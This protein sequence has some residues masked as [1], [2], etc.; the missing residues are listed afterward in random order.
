MPQI[1]PS[2]PLGQMWWHLTASFQPH[3]LP[4]TLIPA[5]S[6]APWK[7]MSDVGSVTPSLTTLQRLPPLKM[8]VTGPYTICP[9]S[10]SCPLQPRCQPLTLFTLLFLL[11][12]FLE[13]LIELQATSFAFC[14]FLHLQSSPSDIFMSH[15]LAYLQFSAFLF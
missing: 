13:C 8:R 6:E 14:N 9:H 7:S 3:P 4:S 11:F 5:A 1:P 10:H 15:S 12:L 2:H